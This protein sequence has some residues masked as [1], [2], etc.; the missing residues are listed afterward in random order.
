MCLCLCFLLL[1]GSS[2]KVS[3]CVS[4][5][6]VKGQAESVEGGTHVGVICE[7]LFYVPQGS[8]MAGLLP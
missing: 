2:K 6:C 1:S 4:L 8:R 7:L 5:E 3:V